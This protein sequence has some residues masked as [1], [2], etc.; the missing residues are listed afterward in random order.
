MRPVA[1]LGIKIVD[2]CSPS[3]Y[4]FVSINIVIKIVIKPGWWV[5]PT[6]NYALARVTGIFRVTSYSNRFERDV[7]NMVS[8]PIWFYCK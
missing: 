2:G 8:Y 1:N 6:S 7:V 4:E 3:K 5:A